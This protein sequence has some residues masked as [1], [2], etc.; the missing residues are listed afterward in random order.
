MPVTPNP[1]NLSE[2]TVTCHQ[3]GSADMERLDRKEYRCKHCGAIT[4]IS[5]DDADRVENLLQQALSRTSFSPAPPQ[6]AAPKQVVVRM[7]A[8]MGFVLAMVIGLPVFFS[9]FN[10]KSDSSGGFVAIGDDT[11]PDEDVTVSQ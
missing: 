5:D 8:M 6:A 2:L 10:D 11:V 4:V 9:L 1:S 7:L 3:C